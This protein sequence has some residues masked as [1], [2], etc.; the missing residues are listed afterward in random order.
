[1]A[2]LAPEYYLP[3]LLVVGPGG[4]KA[5]RGEP[6]AKQ[7]N[8]HLLPGERRAEGPS[9]TG[10]YSLIAMEKSSFCCYICCEAEIV[11]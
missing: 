7:P 8:G 2:A 10:S 3:V 5:A 9:R 11:I 4:R 6:G 1:M